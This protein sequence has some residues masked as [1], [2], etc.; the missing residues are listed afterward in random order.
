[1][2]RQRSGH[3]RLR[4]GLG[5]Q[6]WGPAEPQCGSASRSPWALSL[7]SVPE[8]DQLPPPGRPSSRQHLQAAPLHPGSGSSSTAPAE[9]CL[10]FSNARKQPP[11]Q[12]AI[13]PNSWLNITTS[14][15]WT[16][17]PKGGGQLPLLWLPCDTL[18]S[19]FALSVLY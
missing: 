5:M 19:P 16:P 9:L 4:A 6:C 17:Q 18:G 10:P 1:M 8:K 11:A 14:S 12:A 15:S 3:A 2:S 13:P 7:L